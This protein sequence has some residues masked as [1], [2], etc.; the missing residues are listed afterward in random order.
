MSESLVYKRSPLGE[1]LEGTQT[2]SRNKTLTLLG[3]GQY[4]GDWGFSTESDSHEDSESDG[5]SLTLHAP[6][7]F[8][9]P[10]RI[11]S[12]LRHKRISCQGPLKPLFMAE[13][14]SFQPSKFYHLLTVPLPPTPDP[15]SPVPP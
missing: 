4:D 12:P 13:N 2:L 6:K 8:A 9:P 14:T 11:P 10:S 7:D 3:T 5:A 15:P 1:F